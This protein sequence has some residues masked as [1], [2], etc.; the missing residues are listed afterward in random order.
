M[1]KVEDN[2]IKNTESPDHFT[3]EY[4]DSLKTELYFITCRR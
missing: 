4:I 1:L 3:F 2:E